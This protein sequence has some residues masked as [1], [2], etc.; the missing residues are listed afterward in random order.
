M[1]YEEIKSFSFKVYKTN[2]SFSI[3]Q[4]LYIEDVHTKYKNKN[5][6]GKYKH[7]YTLRD[8]NWLSINKT[9]LEKETNDSTRVKG[10]TPIKIFNYL[11]KLKKFYLENKNKYWFLGNLSPIVNHELWKLPI[12]KINNKKFE[13]FFEKELNNDFINLSILGD[14]IIWN[15]TNINP[16]GKYRFKITEKKYDHP[17]KHNNAT[18]PIPKNS[19]F[20]NTNRIW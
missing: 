4:F 12:N 15:F 3:N 14:K 16:S 9:W 18:I 13:D 11:D 10:Q 17:K 20:G 7:F 1:N 8:M 5:I 2:Y 19:F 6:S